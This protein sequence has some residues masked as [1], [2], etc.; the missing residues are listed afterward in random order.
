M[1][2]RESSPTSRNKVAEQITA[3]G[4]RLSRVLSGDSTHSTETGRTAVTRE[5]KEPGMAALID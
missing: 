3:L 5:S 4:A 1:A 2:D